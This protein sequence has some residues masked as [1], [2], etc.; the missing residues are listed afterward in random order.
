MTLK[1]KLDKEYAY[2]TVQRNKSTSPLKYFKN[3]NTHTYTIPSGK[4]IAKL[5]M[6]KNCNTWLTRTLGHNKG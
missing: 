6:D 4:L 5:S 2:I 1:P 3:G